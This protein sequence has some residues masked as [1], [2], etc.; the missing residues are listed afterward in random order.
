M[1]GNVI[2]AD[3]DDDAV[4]GCGGVSGNVGRVIGRVTITLLLAAVPMFPPRLL[5]NS[6]AVDQSLPLQG[7]AY[8][9]VVL[10]LGSR[11]DVGQVAAFVVGRAEEVLGQGVEDVDAVDAVVGADRDVERHQLVL[12]RCRDAQR[13]LERVDELAELFKVDVLSRFLVKPL[14]HFVVHVEVILRQSL[15]HILG[16]LETTSTPPHTQH[17]PEHG[18]LEVSFLLYSL[19][20]DVHLSYCKISILFCPMGMFLLSPTFRLPLLV[21]GTGTIYLNTSLLHVRC[22]S[23]GRASRLISSSFPYLSP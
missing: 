8:R 17:Q 11:R 5:N 21:F 3:V 18:I 22:L 14:P 19:S 15:L 12:V 10:A 4:A 7:A 16:R 6:C 2:Y 1:I 9:L 20:C 13:L 23:S